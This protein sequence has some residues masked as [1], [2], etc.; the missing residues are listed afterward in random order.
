ME[1]RNLRIREEDDIQQTKG[2]LDDRQHADAQ[3]D[4]VPYLSL[5]IPAATMATAVILMSVTHA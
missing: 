4:G 3:R 5:I 2:I 1:P